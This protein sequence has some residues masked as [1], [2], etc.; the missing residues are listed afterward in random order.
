MQTGLIIKGFYMFEVDLKQR[1]PQAL[2][3]LRYY[4]QRQAERGVAADS[5]GQILTQM[6]AL[7]ERANASGLTAFVRLTSNGSSA[8][9]QL[10]QTNYLC[11]QYERLLENTGD[12]TDRQNL[13][14]MP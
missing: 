11:L 6:S 9:A 3:E 12:F 1:L 4:L 14:K 10:L 13:I 5:A 7:T 2:R 8:F